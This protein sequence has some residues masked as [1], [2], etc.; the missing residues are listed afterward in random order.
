[1]NRVLKRRDES[2]HAPSPPTPISLVPSPQAAP[3][4]PV[5]LPPL[6]FATG[7]P[8]ATAPAVAKPAQP[9]PA[10]REEAPRI[11]ERVFALDDPARQR[12]RDAYVAARF[13]GVARSSHDLA[14]VRS[15]IAAAQAYFE[16]GDARRAEELL[17]FAAEL[18]PAAEALLLARLEI[19]LQLRDSESYRRNALRFHADHPRSAH[20]RYVVAFARTL[21]LTEPPFS[22]D[23]ADDLGDSTYQRPNWIQRS[24]ELAP[25]F[26]ASDLRAR[27]LAVERMEP[28]AERHAA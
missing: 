6:D 23:V 9:A 25:E 11:E 5:E 8:V 20:W 27:V 16:D 26:V 1:M 12:V 13:P 18:Q 19:A 28:E 4:E 22:P 7:Q 17:E 21:Y 10:I 3:R 2:S 24:W 15:V 14:R